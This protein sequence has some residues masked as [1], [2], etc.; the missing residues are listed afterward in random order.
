MR[1]SP[2]QSI[3]MGGEAKGGGRGI[4]AVKPV[5]FELIGITEWRAGGTTR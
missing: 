2:A 1:E 5:A 4:C 3:N